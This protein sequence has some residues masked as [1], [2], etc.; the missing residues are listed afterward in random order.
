MKIVLDTN[1]LVSG[2]LTP[3]GSPAE[4][5]RM[6]A[7]G[8]I[9]LCYDVRI[10]TEYGNV[11]KRPRFQFDPEKID[12]L[13]GQIEYYGSLVAAEPFSDPLPDESDKPFL[14]VAIACETRYLVTG[15][16]KH[17][18]DTLKHRVRI[19]T[20]SEFLSEYGKEKSEIGKKT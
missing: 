1:V 20:A 8:I 14:E 6:V 10:L 16:I 12:I 11:L 5:V 15:N 13:L 3:F 2:L 7:A 18:P 4:I 17:F 9:E 19:V